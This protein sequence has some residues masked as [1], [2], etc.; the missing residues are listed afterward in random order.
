[1]I[2]IWKKKPQ[3][4]EEQTK[5]HILVVQKTCCPLNGLTWIIDLGVVGCALQHPRTQQDYK[6]IWR[7]QWFVSIRC[8]TIHQRVWD[9][10]EAIGRLYERYW[11]VPC[12]GLGSRSA[13]AQPRRLH[14]CESY[15]HWF[16]AK[17]YWPG[18]IRLHSSQKTST[19]FC[20]CHSQWFYSSQKVF[21]AFT[22]YTLET[23]NPLLI[24]DQTQN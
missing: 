6:A 15:G 24:G 9:A 3:S 19:S 16:Q 2:S 1:M 14:P 7:V 17:L 20:H 8:G 5:N 18:G 11:G 13:Y 4:L 22:S 12:K 21:S 10:W 23:Q